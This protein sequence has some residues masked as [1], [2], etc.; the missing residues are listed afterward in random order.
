MLIGLLGNKGSGKDTT[1]NYIKTKYECQVEAFATPLKE[2][3][4][5]LFN[6][7]DEQLYGDKKE[8]VDTR[9]NITPR[10]VFQYIGTDIVRNKFSEIMPHIGNN[11]WIINLENKYREYISNNKSGIFIITDVRFQNEVDFIKKN[12]G[13]VIKIVRNI[14]N[15]DSHESENIDSVNNYDYLL[16]NNG[17]LENLYRKIDK[18]II[19]LGL[20]Q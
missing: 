12:N 17:T 3:V 8:I 20:N 2:T 1:A 6:M 5:I 15:Y 16:E 10:Q 9:W 19:S 13:I 18:I 14:N 7:T 11:F 4:R